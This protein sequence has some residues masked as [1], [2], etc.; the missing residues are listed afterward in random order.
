MNTSTREE[1]LRAARLVRKSE[2]GRQ[3]L[4]RPDSLVD[5]KLNDPGIRG[6]IAGADVTAEPEF[7]EHQCWRLLLV[8]PDDADNRLPAK[9]ECGGC[10]AVFRVEV[11]Y[12]P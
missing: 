3:L 1:I 5:A 2:L 9:L 11:E 6:F 8:Y 4:E 7:V 10:G 12:L